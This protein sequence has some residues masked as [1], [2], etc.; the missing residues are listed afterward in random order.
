MELGATVCTPRQPRCDACPVRAECLAHA[1]GLVDQIP[2]P[3]Q[4]APSPQQDLWAVAVRRAGKLLLTRRPGTGLL[5][6][7]WCLPLIERPPAAPEAPHGSLFDKGRVTPAA[8][9]SATGLRV[10]RIDPLAEP[11]KHV[12]THRVWL[13]WPCR[14]DADLADG[15]GSVLTASTH[16]EWIA[17][18]ERPNG[19]IPTVTERLLERLGY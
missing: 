17:P 10:T 15:S 19:G 4:R 14:A 1:R 12:F 7:M 2:A 6:D 16:F 9:K 11:I 5:A 13:L 18:G 3:K 8:I